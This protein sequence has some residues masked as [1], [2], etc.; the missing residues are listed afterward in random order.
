MSVV[1]VNILTTINEWQSNIQFSQGSAATD[2]RCGGRFYTGFFYSSSENVV[3]K[4]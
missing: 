2:L 1:Y 3:V 4:E